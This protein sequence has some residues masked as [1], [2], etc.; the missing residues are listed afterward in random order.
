[1]NNR[2]AKISI[3]ILIATLI[4]ACNVVKKVPDKK[5]LLTK[6]EILINDKKN[7][8]EDV[9]AQII[10]QPNTSILGYKLR[11]NMYNLAKNNTDSIFRAKYTARP[12]KY[13]RKIKWL[14]KKQVD[15]LGKSFWYSGWHSFLRRTG[16]P[17]VIIDTAKTRRSIKRLR[18]FYFNQG[19]FDAKA[20]FD[21]HYEENKRGNI[22]YKLSTGQPTF[23]D[24]I[25]RE[26]ETPALDSLYLRSK[27]RS[28]IKE[29]QQYKA[30]NFDA[31][32]NRITTYFRN[33]GVYYFQ[34]QSIYFDIDTASKKS[35]VKINI[36]DQIARKGDSTTT[37]P[38]DIY[39]ISEVNIFT[40][41]SVSKNRQKV[42]D[43][44]KYGNFNLYSSNKL[45]YR[46]R[47]ITNAVFIYKDSVYSDSKRTQTLRSLNNLRI[48]NYPNIT[49]TEDTISKTLKTNIY[50]VS[51]DKFSFRA[52]ADFTHSNI[53]DFGISGST[54]VSI[55]NLFRGAE[56]LELGL[57]G[58][59]G[60]SKDLA[61]PDDQFFNISEIGTDLR[62]SFPRLFL[63]FGTEKIVPKTMFP[64]SLISVG[65]AKQRN[66]GLDKENFTTTINYSWTPGRNTSARFDLVNIQYVKNINTKNYFNVYRS[67]YTKLNDFAGTYNTN[68]DYV[69]EFGNL[70]IAQGGA[71]MFLEGALN[72]EFPS[73]DPA[74]TDFRSIKSIKERKDRLTENNLIFASNF[75]YSKDSKTDFFDKEFYSFRGKIE[76]AGNVLS[77]AASLSNQPKSEDGTRTVFGLQ[78][79]QYIKTEFDYIKH[80]DLGNYNIFAVRSF[81]G[82]AIPYGNSKSIPFS[83]SYFAGGSNDNRAWQSYS[84]GPGRSGGL[85]DFNEAN[86][87]IALNAEF[88]YRYFGS[89]YGALFADCGNIW[90]VLDNETD[91]TKVFTGFSSLKDLA[92]GTGIG[93]RYDFKFFVARV[94]FGFK[95]YNPAKTENE[96]WFKELNLSK[97]VL[98][99]GINY[100]F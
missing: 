17:P 65:F 61:N 22:V 46:P 78:Y 8:Q 90:N 85:N 69:D 49:Y 28:I 7:S 21:I 51:K 71:D 89:F 66:I 62:L 97:S 48:F 41:D 50:L 99:I 31:E 80:W 54:S 87:K 68:P 83:R 67:S 19:Y 53:Q 98:N 42:A 92:L 13:R 26:I 2:T 1:M 23:L 39:R 29:G 3:F 32:R 77:L 63:P 36:T 6:N 93:F 57:R 16:E 64:N 100:P 96:R 73:L 10:Q 4:S 30:E 40:T 9:V 58:N 27:R 59:I 84:L 82:I 72:N 14:S 33:H 25:S 91:E 70:T 11:L 52:N 60:S 34:Q 94:D 88:R 95:T 5:F 35:P 24:T 37:K 12:D 76:S 81:F 56:I 44:A 18:A 38:Y 55:R 86:M 79:S 45:R 15:R 43:S 74:G 47:A 20:S 75:S